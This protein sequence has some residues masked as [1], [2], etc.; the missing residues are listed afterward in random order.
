M[1]RAFMAAIARPRPEPRS[2]SGD[3]LIPT[4]TLGRPLVAVHSLFKTP[5][6]LLGFV[7]GRSWHLA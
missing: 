1:A 5:V 7:L 2:R 4:L 3:T 6:G